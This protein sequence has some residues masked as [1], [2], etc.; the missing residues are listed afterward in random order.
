MTSRRTSTSAPKS[1]KPPDRADQSVSLWYLVS[2]LTKDSRG[3][4]GYA[5]ATLAKC[6][7]AAAVGGIAA[8]WCL[9]GVVGPIAPFLVG[10]SVA[11]CATALKAWQADSYAARTAQAQFPKLFDHHLRTRHPMEFADDSD[12]PLAG[13]GDGIT[14]SGWA[15]LAHQYARPTVTSL[16]LG[17]EATIRDGYAK[18]MLKKV[19]KA[20]LQKTSEEIPSPPSAT[21]SL[22]SSVGEKGLGNE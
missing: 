10:S 1:I 9:A 14:R 15:I 22:A 11:W 12:G 2:S 21:R 19:K 18:A 7:A 20:K 6:S 4:P 5:V 13:D 8:E 16:Q 3:F 17:S